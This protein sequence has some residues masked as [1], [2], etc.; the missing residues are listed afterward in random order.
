MDRMSSGTTH[1]CPLSEVMDV[2][3][4]GVPA[5]EE[6]EAVSTGS[7]RTPPSVVR[8][9]TR[10]GSSEPA[11][12]TRSTERNDAR[13]NELFEEVLEEDDDAD[14]P[15][16]ASPAR[17]GS[18]YVAHS[19]SPSRG[20]DDHG[21]KWGVSAWGLQIAEEIAFSVWVRAYVAVLL[22][23]VLCFTVL[24]WARLT[25][26][27]TLR[28]LLPGADEFWT[29]VS[30]LHAAAL[31][32]TVASAVLDCNMKLLTHWLGMTRDTVHLFYLPN[33]NFTARAIR[34]RNAQLAA[35]LCATL[36]APLLTAVVLCA[37]ANGAFSFVGVFAFAAFVAMCLIVAGVFVFMWCV[38][39]RN[40][41]RAWKEG[42]AMR[43]EHETDVPE[44]EVT[45][46][47]LRLSANPLVMAEF[48]LDFLTVRTYTAHVAMGS[49]WVLFAVLTLGG[50]VSDVKWVALVCILLGGALFLAY[51][52]AK[53]AKQ[54][55][56]IARRQRITT[57]AALSCWTLFT[58]FGILGSAFSGDAQMLLLTLALIA[59]SQGQLLRR[60]DLHVTDSMI[61]PEQD[62]NEDVQ[63]T[64][65]LNLLP[66]LD[67]LRQCHPKSSCISKKSRRAMERLAQ[68]TSVILDHHCGALE[69]KLNMTQR[70][71]TAD[72]KA[73]TALW[74][75]YMVVFCI[76]CSLSTTFSEDIETT[77]ATGAADNSTSVGSY[78]ACT[79]QWGSL[80]TPDLALLTFIAQNDAENVAK[81][82]HTLYGESWT[83]LSTHETD[84]LRPDDLPRVTFLNKDENMSVVVAKASEEHA[85]RWA[86]DLDIWGD[87]V[88]AKLLD[89]TIPFA[90]SWRAEDRRGLVDVSSA[91]SR[92][93]GNDRHVAGAS[94]KLH[95]AAL[96]ANGTN[97]VVT[98][99]GTPAGHAVMADLP[100]QVVAFGAP[101]TFYTATAKQS[102]HIN[103]AMENA[104]FSL[105][106]NEAGFL[107]EVHCDAGLFEC[108]RL[109]KLTC[110][111]LSG[112]GKT[113]PISGC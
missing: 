42:T 97:V 39:L 108:Q 109:R 38:A 33:A 56:R 8:P 57:V 45:P 87:S 91:L 49:L 16:H 14:I 106:D 96:L 86:Y 51:T 21:M 110:A 101:G 75:V 83:V 17:A 53:P 79:M 35:L 104:L 105:L 62:G 27:L 112:C 58:L 92:F 63:Y 19:R 29:V 77:Q 1:G 102:A 73:A 90:S 5:M 98:G 88:L 23:S 103:V 81:D 50:D 31:L 44:D 22:M 74:F 100:V 113:V 65:Y 76:V 9:Q 2:D 68:E 67:A 94:L 3:S 4:V 7:Q 20:R 24:L 13:S 107:Q 82:L 10:R 28:M 99:H 59:L 36:L 25:Y 71:L 64:R 54:A 34:M 11:R 41:R 46:W 69:A 32:V 66:C 26:T 18:P 6:M 70:V 30:S 95:V 84:A 61:V 85:R 89:A 72:A 43:K 111:F 78:A 52:A 55:T 40:K 60:H 15:E 37:T 80:A 47:K 12:R 48:G 93:A